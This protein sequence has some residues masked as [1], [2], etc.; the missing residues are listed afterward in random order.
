MAPELIHDAAVIS[1]VAAVMV[2]LRWFK[3]LPGLPFAPGHKNAVLLPLYIIASEMTHSRFGAT[4]AGLTMGI[5]GFLSGDG[6]YGIFEVFK[7]AAP[8]FSR[9]SCTPSFAA[10]PRP[11]SPCTPCSA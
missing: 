9:T 1:G 6:R 5:I 11:E 4:V 7:H 2:S 3:T 8:G 10:F